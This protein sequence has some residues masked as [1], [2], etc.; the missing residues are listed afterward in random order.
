MRYMRNVYTDPGP[1]AINIEDYDLIA[2][3]KKPS[4]NYDIRIPQ[5]NCYRFLH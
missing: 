4:R 5:E 1:K 3:N 2:R